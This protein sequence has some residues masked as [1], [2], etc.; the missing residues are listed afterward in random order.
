MRAAIAFVVFTAACAGTPAHVVDIQGQRLSTTARLDADVDPIQVHCGLH[1][2]LVVPE[3]N[4]FLLGVHVGTRTPYVHDAAL[5]CERIR[6][7]R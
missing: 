6:A 4:R 1:K 7:A 3:P 2:Y 5:L